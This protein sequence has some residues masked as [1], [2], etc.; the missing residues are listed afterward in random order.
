MIWGVLLIPET[1][2]T[3]TWTYLRWQM[4]ISP[5]RQLSLPKTKHQI[6]SG[7]IIGHTLFSKFGFQMCYVSVHQKQ[8]IW[9]VLSCVVIYG[10]YFVGHLLILKNLVTYQQL[11]SVLLLYHFL[12]HFVSKRWRIRR[13]KKKT[14]FS[15]DVREKSP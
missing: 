8:Y 2:F 9:L 10:C 12:G 3:H 1:I 6:P 14:V 13:R 7:K 4:K 5:H 11:W 15:Q